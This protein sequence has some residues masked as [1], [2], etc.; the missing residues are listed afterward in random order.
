MA[1]YCS[2]NMRITGGEAEIKE[3]IS[4]LN[5]SNTFEDNC[6]SGVLSC[7]AEDLQATSSLNIYEVNCRGVCAR[8]VKTDMREN[9]HS[10]R[11]LEN[12]SSRLGLVIEAYSIEIGFGF[13]EHFLVAKGDV[14][15]DACVDYAEHCLEGYPSIEEYNAKNNTNFTKE[16]VNEDGLVCVGG[17]GAQYGNWED[18]L[19][20]FTAE[21]VIPPLSAQIKAAVGKVQTS[22]ANDNKHLK[23]DRDDLQ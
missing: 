11:S 3:M 18:V 17:F 16:M 21:Q 1:N 23:D 5:R 19:R 12:E 8:S 22:I 14:L 10:D 4:M 2:F 9:P 13:Q 20:F 7:I 15:I 6:F